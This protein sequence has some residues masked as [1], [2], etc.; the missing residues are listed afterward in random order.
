MGQQN[1]EGVAATI[2]DIDYDG[3]DAKV[4]PVVFASGADEIPAD[5]EIGSG[6]VGFI[7]RRILHLMYLGEIG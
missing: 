7:H 2:Q 3:E 6:M 5:P 4:I 1:G